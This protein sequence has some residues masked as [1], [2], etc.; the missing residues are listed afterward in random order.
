MRKKVYTVEEMEEKARQ[1]Y[2]WEYD[3]KEWLHIS[4]VDTEEKARRLLK[5]RNPLRVAKVAENTCKD[6]ETR[7][8]GFCGWIYNHITVFLCVT[9]LILL[10]AFLLPIIHGVSFVTFYNEN[11]HVS[12][13][14]TVTMFI[15]MIIFFNMEL[16]TRKLDLDDASFILC[17]QAEDLKNGFYYDEFG[18]TLSFQK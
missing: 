4:Q 12:I 14:M 18:R 9:A 1:G 16:K 8:E 11:V 2:F 6:V 10:A 3:L 15:A 13:I 7:L 17:T 5:R